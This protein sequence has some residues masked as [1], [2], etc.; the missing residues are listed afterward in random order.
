MGPLVVSALKLGAVEPRRRLRSQ[1]QLS[2]PHPTRGRPRP[3]AAH[4]EEHAAGQQAALRAEDRSTYGAARSAIVMVGCRIRRKG[5][6][7]RLQY[8][9][10]ARL[11]DG[12]LAYEQ[13]KK[14]T[15]RVV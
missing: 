2:L 15:R 1:G 7:V 5:Y 8:D 10:L 6:Q 13:K 11:M 12:R 14:P 4:R 9:I 3:D